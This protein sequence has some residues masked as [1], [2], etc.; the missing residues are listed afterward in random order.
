M[1]DWKETFDSAMEL[2]EELSIRN[3]THAGFYV[4]GDGTFGLVSRR[5]VGGVVER[6]SGR[7]E[8]DARVTFYRF[9]RPIEETAFGQGP[10]PT[11]RD[12]RE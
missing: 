12:E 5:T 11:V 6:F 4:L 10:I 9:D 1:Y 2:M 3:V 7:I 8:Y